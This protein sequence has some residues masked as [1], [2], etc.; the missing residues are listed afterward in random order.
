MRSCAASFSLFA[1]ISE[2]VVV[3]VMSDSVSVSSSGSCS[4]SGACV[5]VCVG[6]A[7]TVSRR[8]LRLCCLFSSLSCAWSSERVS[9]VSNSGSIPA[10]RLL[11]LRDWD[12]VA[13]DS[14]VVPV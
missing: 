3:P 6:R 9:A 11:R 10:I 7:T 1:L 5:S 14:A 12:P 2:K 4:G 8:A 13:L